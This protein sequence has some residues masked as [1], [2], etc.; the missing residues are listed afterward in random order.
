MA[1]R[2]HQPFELVKSTCEAMQVYM[3]FFVQEGESFAFRCWAF[4]FLLLQGRLSL[5]AREHSGYGA[6]LYHFCSSARSRFSCALRDATALQTSY[7]V[8]SSLQFLSLA[9]FSLLGVTRC[10]PTVPFGVRFTG[11]YAL[12]RNGA[13][14][15]FAEIRPVIIFFV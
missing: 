9:F 12:K 10:K 5:N 15:F 6:G 11:S 2:S 7:R 1:R 8:L 3:E 14:W 13:F 4:L